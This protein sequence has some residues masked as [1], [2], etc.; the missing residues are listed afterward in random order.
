MLA[1]VSQTQQLYLVI[2]HDR[3]RFL[4][5][6]LGGLH[7]VEDGGLDSV[8]QSGQHVTSTAWRWE[9]CALQMKGN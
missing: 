9:K 8:N 7:D 3:T 4:R 5:P 6:S 2:L 1:S